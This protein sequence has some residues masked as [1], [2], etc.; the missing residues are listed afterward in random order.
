MVVRYGASGYDTTP[1][2]PTTVTRDDV[3][4]D[5]TLQRTTWRRRETFSFSERS[6]R[7]R[8]FCI[9]QRSRLGHRHRATG[10]A[11]V[12]GDTRL[13]GYD[14]VVSSLP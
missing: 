10:R 5:V 1:T 2:R 14:T 8:C 12:Y 9:R 3:P 11:T 4:Q 6:Q 13:R 7:S